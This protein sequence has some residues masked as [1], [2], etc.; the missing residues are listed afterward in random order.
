[1][2][3]KDIVAHEDDVMDAKAQDDRDMERLGKAQQLKRNFR[4]YS[5]L[6]FTTTLMATWESIL[7][8]STYG[9]V[10][11]GRAGMVYVYI[12]SYV[13]FFASVI[14]MAEISS[15]APTSA[16]QYHWVS[17]FAAPRWQRFLSYLTGL[18][19]VLGWQAAFA[20]ICF[21]CGTLIQGL[22]VFNYSRDTGYI[23]VDE[24]WHGTLLTIAIAA[25][26][27][28]VNTY[29]AAFLAPLEGIILCLHLLGFLAV[30]VLF[31]VM[32]PG[33]APSTEVW[34]EFTNSGGW[35]S[36][37]LAC[38]VGQLT[39]VFSWTGPDAATHMAEE[40]R[41]AAVVV[42]WC[43]VST[44]LINGGLGFIMLTTF[45]YKMGDIA[46]VV[47]PASG[48]SFL[49]ATHHATGSV[50][51]TNGVASIVLVMEIFSAIGILT[52]ASR[53]TFAFARDRGLPFSRS[54]AHV[55]TRSQIPVISVLV[56]TIITVL[57]SL[58][59]IGSTAA[60]NAIASVMVAA[61]FTTYILSIA[62]FVRARLQP[63]GIPPSQF[64]LGRLGLPINLFS[65]AWMCFSVIFTF[66][67]TTNNPTLADMNWSILVFG[68]VFIFAILQYLFHGRRI[69]QAPVIQVRKME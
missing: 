7:L 68:V 1:M 61:L 66:F 57:L 12:G 15:I 44:A 48:F 19:S 34:T 55:D 25:I 51:A 64:S 63:T 8:T 27:T 10:D 5:I 33:Q 14:S 23:Y 59:N 29:G 49:P 24:R 6:G 42:P 26:G 67:P 38:L 11:G 53:Q 20:S 31:W 46:D 45:L 69:Y 3:D 2:S 4:F 36:M 13:G 58:I 40:V 39:P 28:L 21:L 54:L 62:A 30:L 50:A 32:N 41:N 35:S 22:L 47:H 52:T 18:L 37:G 9:L 17:E 56:S 65:L 16:G 43:M 60:F